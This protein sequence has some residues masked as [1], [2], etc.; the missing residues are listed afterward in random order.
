[1]FAMADATS[2]AFIIA[3][4]LAPVL[5]V[6]TRYAS[7]MLAGRQDVTNITYISSAWVLGFSASFL[8]VRGMLAVVAITEA[9]CTKH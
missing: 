8:H 6:P 9:D 1:M 3:L 5:V 4:L 7:G 2:E